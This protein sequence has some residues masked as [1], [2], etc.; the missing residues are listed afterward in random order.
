MRTTA[1]TA[2][3]ARKKAALAVTALAALTLTLTACNGDGDGDGGGDKASRAEKR[4]ADASTGGPA[5]TTSGGSGSGS[6][7]AAPLSGDACTPTAAKIELEDTA[8]TAPLVLLKITNNGGKTCSVFGAPFVSDP[9]AGKNLP[10]AE[11]T[12]PQSVVRV[13]PA[14]SAY[15]AISLAGIDAEK[16]HRAKTLGVTLATKDGKGT[17]G[18]VTVNSPGAAGLLLNADSQVTYWQNTLE[19]AMS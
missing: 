17:D 14:K 11:N 5:A 2:R 6:G 8:G 9:A 3:V 10:V 7:S 16:T 15:A 1:R 4:S 19:D 18:R 12:R 13:E